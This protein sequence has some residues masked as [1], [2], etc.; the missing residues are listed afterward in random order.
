[1]ER[2]TDCRKGN[3]DEKAVESETTVNGV[4]LSALHYNVSV[5][6]L[7]HDYSLAIPPPPFVY[8]EWWYTKTN[9]TAVESPPYS[10]QRFIF[11]LEPPKPCHRPL[12]IE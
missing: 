4:C 10:P 1:M 8:M 12:L 11:L 3:L 7:D 5:F 2:R 9:E 6:Q